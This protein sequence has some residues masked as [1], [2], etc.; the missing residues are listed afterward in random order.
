[1]LLKAA[2]SSLKLYRH[3]K[4]CPEKLIPEIF[5]F[6]ELMYAQKVFVVILAKLSRFIIIVLFKLILKYTVL[7]SC[8]PINDSA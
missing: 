8:D 7:W 6:R 3:K 5:L 2:D 4:F 1:M